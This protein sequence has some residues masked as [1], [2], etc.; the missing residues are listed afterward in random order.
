MGDAVFLF[1]ICWV[2]AYYDLFFVA[3]GRSLFVSE[4]KQTLF[5]EVSLDKL[6]SIG[7]T[8]IFSAGHTHN[9]TNYT[10][11]QLTYINE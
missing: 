10:K 3:P 5:Y 6:M 8:S 4:A 7:S 9:L 2:V 11:N 1:W